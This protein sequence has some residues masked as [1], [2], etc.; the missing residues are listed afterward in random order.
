MS[1]RVGWPASLMTFLP[2]G[3]LPVLR[4]YAGS[5]TP[6][7]WNSRTAGRAASPRRWRPRTGP[8]GR[9]TS[10][11]A[12]R[13][14]QGL[15][16]RAVATR[17]DPRPLAVRRVRFGQ[18]L[19]EPTAVN[20]D[21]AQHLGVAACFAAVIPPALADMILCPLT[22]GPATP[23]VRTPPPPHLYRLGLS[24]HGMPPP[25]PPRAPCPARISAN[26]L[27]TSLTPMYPPPSGAATLPPLACPRG[28]SVSL[29]PAL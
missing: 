7:G 12:A 4:P 11:R 13:S 15:P 26:R 27:R 28:S 8:T 1:H 2:S 24:A 29:W 5:Y 20:V 25:P 6:S 22:G 3:Q 10:I 21:A 18:I 17:D 23:A 16:Q 9:D 19:A 14:R